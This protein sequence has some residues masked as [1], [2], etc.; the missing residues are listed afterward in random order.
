M[1]LWGQ[2]W[3]TQTLRCGYHKLLAVSHWPISIVI[4][5]KAIFFR[6][7]SSSELDQEALEVVAKPSHMDSLDHT[8]KVGKMTS[9]YCLVYFKKSSGL[10][11]KFSIVGLFV[12][13]THIFSIK[14]SFV[15]CNQ[16]HTMQC[17][18]IGE[19]Y[20]N[21]LTTSSF[22]LVSSCWSCYCTCQQM[23]YWCV[24]QLQVIKKIYE[25]N[26]LLFME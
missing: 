11:T 13:A 8:F 24:L 9:V 17:L 10:Y 22:Y 16:I 20:G 7:C 26:F 3:H 2:N 25:I 23:Q 4:V 1:K 15:I 18:G 5:A 19:T 21:E 12:G 14:M 6:S